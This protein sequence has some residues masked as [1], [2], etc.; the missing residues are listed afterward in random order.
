MKLSLRNVLIFAAVVLFV[1][2]A[3]YFRNIVAYILIS[4]VLSF[5]GR[6]LVDLLGRVRLWKYRIPKAVSALV[7]I[8][9]LW[10]SIILV[11]YIFIP[12]ITRQV[13]Q[14]ASIDSRNIVQL[15]ESPLKKL[16]GVIAYFNGNLADGISIQGYVM[17]RISEIL[18]AGFIQNFLAR[19]M[20]IFGNLAVAFFSITFITFF[21]L[22]DERLFYETIMIWIPAK[23]EEGARRALSSIKHLLSRYFI[24]IIIQSTCVMIL[25]TTGMLLVGLQFQQALTIGLISG[26]LNVIPYVGPWLAGAIGIVMGVASSLEMSFSG[27]VLPLVSYM[28]LVIVVT[29]I[30]DNVVFQP[31]IFSNSVNA[32]PLEIFIVIL[33]AGSIA[34]VVGMILAIPSYTILRVI[35]REF[36][37]NFKAVRKLTSG[38]E[39]AEQRQAGKQQDAGTK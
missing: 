20:S 23:Y 25:I 39:Q 10:T 18:S 2:A 31:L 15:I 4:G 21:F 26:T 33:V 29:H 3:W 14:F 6:P 36:F 28:L 19:L 32:H 1:L 38:L 7:T 9:A 24:G 37:N 12:L 17:S 27:V 13:N 22:K 30:I 5:I 34:G 11:L 35:G 8:V 16:D